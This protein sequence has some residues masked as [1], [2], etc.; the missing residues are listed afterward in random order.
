VLAGQLRFPEIT[1]G[2]AAV[3]EH[4]A[5]LQLRPEDD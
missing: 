5:V 2:V 3:D 1:I 4:G